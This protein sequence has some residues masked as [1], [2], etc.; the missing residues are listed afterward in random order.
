MRLVGESNPLWRDRGHFFA[1]AAEAMRR[2][3]VDQA[4]RRDAI[5]RGGD[6]Q[7]VELDGLSPS[8]RAGLQRM[9]E[10]PFDQLAPLLVQRLASVA[11]D[12]PAISVHR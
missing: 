9:S 8:H 5:K 4:R 11:L 7:R 12:P 10:A 3:L 6:R 1:A 2:I